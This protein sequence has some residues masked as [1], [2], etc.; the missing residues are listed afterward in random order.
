MAAAPALL[1]AL[2]RCAK[3]LAHHH[4]TDNPCQLCLTLSEEAHKMIKEA[5]GE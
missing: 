5:K 1:A 3:E 4:E 2:G